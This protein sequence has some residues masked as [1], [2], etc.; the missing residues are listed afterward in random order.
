MNNIS[1]N[2]FYRQFNILSLILIIRNIKEVIIKTSDKILNF[3]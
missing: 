3:L 2:K 1:F